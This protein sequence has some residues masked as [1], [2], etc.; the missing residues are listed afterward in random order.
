VVYWVDLSVALPLGPLQAQPSARASA[1][2]RETVSVKDKRKKSI[3]LRTAIAWQDASADGLKSPGREG[4]PSRG[5]EESGYLD[6]R[7]IEAACDGMIAVALCPGSY[8]L[9]HLKPLK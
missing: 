1:S 3:A 8:S 4:H 6:R 2:F 7:V 5:R 9:G